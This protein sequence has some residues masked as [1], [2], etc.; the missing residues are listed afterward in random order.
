MQSLTQRQREILS[1]LIRLYLDWGE[2]VASADIADAIGGK[3][4]S[5][6]IRKE[7]KALE[8]MGFLEHPYKVAGR[9]PTVKAYRWF[10]NNLMYAPLWDEG[11]VHL[12][13]TLILSAREAAQAIRSVVDEIA[14]SVREMSM[15]TYVP[16]EAII[17]D[18]VFPK[19]DDKYIVGLLLSTGEF[20][21]VFVDESQTST[22]ALEDIKRAVVG[23][24]LK[25]V[26][27][28]RQLYPAWF[29]DLVD[30]AMQVRVMESGIEYLVDK[31]DVS[32]RIRH[33]ITK[34]K[35]DDWYERIMITTSEP[36]IMFSEEFTDGAVKDWMIMVVHYSHRGLEGIIGLVGPRRYSP[37]RIFETLWAAKKALEETDDETNRS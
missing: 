3:W 20:V 31:G 7:L 21:K 27:E 36:T 16:S 15:G 34:L 5:A 24:Y 8:D 6:T 25:D 18:M 23:R 1:T 37:E 10:F 32:G 14:T 29:S 11:S 19:V 4:S 13:K 28:S 22:G 2:P 9:Y 17:V 35:R 30:R 12:F 26:Y 33:L